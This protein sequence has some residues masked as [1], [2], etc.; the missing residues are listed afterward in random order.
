MG[1]HCSPDPHVTT[2]T[3]YKFNDM[4]DGITQVR[5]IVL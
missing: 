3:E 4:S 5:R 1:M 2:H